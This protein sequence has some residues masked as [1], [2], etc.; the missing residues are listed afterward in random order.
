MDNLYFPFD[1][2]FKNNHIFITQDYTAHHSHLLGYE[3]IKINKEPIH[4][5]INK[6]FPIV[7]GETDSFK[8]R[9]L[10]FDLGSTRGIT[11]NN[12]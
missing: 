10:E 3:I 11:C 12:C 6:M 1:I 4:D 2:A 5:L 8:K 7:T 9:N